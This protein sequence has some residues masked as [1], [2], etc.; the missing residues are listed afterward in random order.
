MQIHSIHPFVFNSSVSW[1]CYVQTLFSLKVSTHLVSEQA[2]SCTLLWH[3]L[4]I[5]L[6]ASVCGTCCKRWVVWKGYCY[7]MMISHVLG[8]SRLR[9]KSQRIKIQRLG[10]IFYRFLNPY[11]RVCFLFG[12]HKHLAKV[13]RLLVRRYFLRFLKSIGWY[14]YFVVLNVFH[15]CFV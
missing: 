7:L 10:Y 12:N 14:G 15:Q 11:P 9:W 5:S 1:P 3:W 2:L 8:Q 4:A 13:S 6:P